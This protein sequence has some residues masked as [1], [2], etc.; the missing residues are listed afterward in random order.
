ML[1]RQKAPISIAEPKESKD[2]L[3]WVDDIAPRTSE[4]KIIRSPFDNTRTLISHADTT[5]VTG[6]DDDQYSRNSK[7]LDSF[8]FQGTATVAPIDVSP[9]YQKPT[10][11]QRRAEKQLGHSLAEVVQS[12]R[13]TTRLRP[14]TLHNIPNVGVSATRSSLQVT[15]PAAPQG[16][17]SQPSQ[18]V[19][20]TQSLTWK[21][22]ANNGVENHPVTPEFTAW[23][24]VEQDLL[25]MGLIK[26]IPGKAESGS[27]VVPR[28]FEQW[29]QF[30]ADRAEEALAENAEK[31]RRK[32]SEAKVA[33][34]LWG[35]YSDDNIRHSLGVDQGPKKRVKIES[36]MGGRKY[37]DG[38]SAVLSHPTMW[39]TWYQPTE[40]HPEAPW[41][42]LEEMKEEGD[43][44]HTSSFGRFPALPRTPGNPTVVWKVKPV[45]P[46]LPFDEVWKLPD[47]DTWAQ[48]YY[49]KLGDADEKYMECLIGQSLLDALN[50]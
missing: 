1:E 24:K 2:V 20:H 7:R 14:V 26:R 4:G 23:T 11:A 37:R 36:A 45:I 16:T 15:I 22:S 27:F 29:L 6:D 39:S 3:N 32:S 35:S 19:S 31:V 13:S 21:R 38:R 43:E 30:R 47:R 10:L 12:A 44:R 25:R 46:A 48:L 42:C 50:A 33:E 8:A 5:G 41:P 17:P 28:S 40:I 18:P 9:L 34:Q 49:Q